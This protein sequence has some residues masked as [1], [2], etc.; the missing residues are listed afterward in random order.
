ME[1]KESEIPLNFTIPKAGET[2][3]CPKCSSTFLLASGEEGINFTD[4]ESVLTE[5][6]RDARIDGGCYL[7][8]GADA[9]MLGEHICRK[10]KVCGYSW[11]EAVNK[12]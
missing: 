8:F 7:W 1:E 12:K 4:Q 10:C 11:P 6:H 2:T 3:A 9:Y 5:Y